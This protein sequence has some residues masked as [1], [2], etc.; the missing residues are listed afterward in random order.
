MGSILSAVLGHTRHIGI[1]PFSPWATST[2]PPPRCV[3]CRIVEEQTRVPPLRRSAGAMWCRMERDQTKQKRERVAYMRIKVFFDGGHTL[4]VA[5]LLFLRSGVVVL[6]R[7]EAR[8]WHSGVL[9]SWIGLS[10]GPHDLR[11]R[12]HTCVLPHVVTTRIGVMV[13]LV[14]VPTECRVH[15][16]HPFMCPYFFYRITALLAQY[17]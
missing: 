1:G 13:Q 7:R 10:G 14:A 15:R 16:G 6:S 4:E 8:H 5:V 9:A 2:H 11:P 3:V 17:F 12:V